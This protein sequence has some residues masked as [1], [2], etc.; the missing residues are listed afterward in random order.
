MIPLHAYLTMSAIV[1]QV[2]EAVMP[3]P[4][5]S[6]AFAEFNVIGLMKHGS[7]QEKS[8]VRLA[9]QI[10]KGFDSTADAYIVAQPGIQ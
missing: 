2:Y 3:R 8:E 5:A 9:S 6:K 10:P 1:G 4:L 7:T